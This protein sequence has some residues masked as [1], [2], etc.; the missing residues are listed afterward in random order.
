MPLPTPPPMR[1]VRDGW[2]IRREMTKAEA[3]A[4]HLREAAR[5]VGRPGQRH[6]LDEAD[7][8]RVWRDRAEAADHT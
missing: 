8:N 6:H 7:R 5:L 1:V 4:W 2:L 3:E